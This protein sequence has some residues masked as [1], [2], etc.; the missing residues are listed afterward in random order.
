MRRRQL[1]SVGVWAAV[2]WFGGCVTNGSTG[3]ATPT[4]ES[5]PGT[6]TQAQGLGT[7][8]YTV[9]NEDDEPHQVGVTM[10]DASGRV[11]QETN[12]PSL[13]PGGSVSSGSA[14]H[15]PG[16]G[17]FTLRFS[18][19]GTVETYVWNVDDCARVDLKVTITPDQGITIEEVLCQN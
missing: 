13:D 9:T 6:P 2:P 14:G 3:T 19:E 1:L 18:I 11:V 12:E 17:P 10:E 16:M 7:I 15:E 4:K 5:D 8:E